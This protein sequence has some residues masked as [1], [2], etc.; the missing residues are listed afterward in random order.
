MKLVDR[1]TDKI[2]NDV[3]IQVLIKIILILLAIF[4]LQK[5]SVIWT[6]LLDKIWAVIKPFVFGFVIAYI[7]HGPIRWG[8]DHKISKNIM[9]PVLYIL[10]FA[11]LYILI[12]SLLPMIVNQVTSLINSVISGVN[13]LYD[14]LNK[15]TDSSSPGWVEDLVK[16][17][18]T[19]LSDLKDMI[20]TVSTSLP[21]V[22][23]N[24]VSGF[25]TFIF[26]IIISIYVCFGWDKIRFNIYRL[27]RNHSRKTAGTLRAVNKEVSDYLRSVFILIIIKFV[28][29]SLVYFLIGN[30]DWMM[31]GLIT[32][33]SILIPYLG[34]AVANFIG[35]LTSLS[36]PMA[37]WIAL[38]II[39]VI[40]SN[41]DG[42]VIDPM[43]HSH[44]T[45][46][47][48]LWAIF[49]VF[50][51]NAILGIPGIIISIP[52]FLSIRIIIKMYTGVDIAGRLSDSD[53][54]DQSE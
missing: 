53:V 52:A 3:S 7:L 1:I 2:E 45:N 6:G 10:I 30:P 23:S 35:I 47:T 9:I 40:L 43:V 33:L 28:E 17:S 24:L 25:T 34:P 49:S 54:L 29:Y 38:I 26:S 16:Q 36:L 8:E 18:I 20:P 32:G 37:N 11:L 42:A 27:A 46:V 50:A 51:G 22:V 19:A 21:D 39:L 13:W 5:T 4:L 14:I 48:P 31:L 12:A 44:N 41:V 15:Y